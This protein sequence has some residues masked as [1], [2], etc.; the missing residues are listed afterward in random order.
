MA[1]LFWEVIS[2]IF[3]PDMHDRMSTILTTAI[4]L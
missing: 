2:Q 4:A 1:F 3:H